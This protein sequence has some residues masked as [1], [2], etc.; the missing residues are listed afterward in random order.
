MDSKEKII[1]KIKKLLSLASNNT[2]DEESMSALNKAQELMVQYKIQ[3]NEIDATDQDK[4]CIHKTTELRFSPTSS[5]MYIADL[6]D[7]IAENF[8]CVTYLVKRYAERYRYIAFMGYEE[9][10][11]LAIEAM[12][13]ANIAIVRG[14][15]RVY[16][17]LCKKYGIDYVPAKIFNPNKIG[18]AKGYLK[19]LKESFK[20]QKEEHQEWGLVLVA[21][22]EAIDYISDLSSFS[23]NAS[24]NR[25]TSNYY[26]EGYGDGKKFNMSKRLDGRLGIEG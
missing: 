11:D 2:S 26:D 18:Y 14:Y 1:D 20:T 3:E 15:N 12:T 24:Y 5:D 13:L 19:G 22:Q 10:V 7:I 8:C 21:P 6:A 25:S 17:D 16:N 9:D 4:K 23:M